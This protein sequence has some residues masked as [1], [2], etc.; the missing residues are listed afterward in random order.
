MIDTQKPPLQGEFEARLTQ[1]KEIVNS[2]PHAHQAAVKY[3][4]RFL[5][6]VTQHSEQNR[7]SPSNLA[8]VFGPNIL[9]SPS[10]TIASVMA[11]APLVNLVTQEMI[12]HCG[13]I[14]E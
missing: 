4:F 2:L 1:I 7:M 9:R 12:E 8:I 6:E 10:E 14:M 13:R 11:D 3:L 5:N